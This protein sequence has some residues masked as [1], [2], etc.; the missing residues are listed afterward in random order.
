M[1]QE[2]VPLFLIER[3]TCIGYVLNVSHL[4]IPFHL[5]TLSLYNFLLLWHMKVVSFSHCLSPC[6]SSVRVGQIMPA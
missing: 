6:C 4:I 1:P 3:L 5:Q 2:L